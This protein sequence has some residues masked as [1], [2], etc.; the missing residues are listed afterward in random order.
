MANFNDTK[1]DQKY[2]KRNYVEVL[3]IL[4][5]DF[6]LDEDINTFGK[7]VSPI[8]ELINSHIR[9]ASSFNTI[10]NISGTTGGLP[11]RALSGI[12]SYF[13]KQNDILKLD[14]FDFERLVLSPLGKKLKD[15]TTSGEFR[16]YVVSSLLPNIRLN[17]PNYLFGQTTKADAHD[18]L[19]E[20]L[21]WLYFLNL[22]GPAG[23]SYQPSAYVAN[24]M[25]EKLYY[26]DTI[27]LNDGIKG[28]E[29]YI[30][31][32]TG[33]CSLF[34][35]FIPTNFTARTGQYTS[36]TQQLE[37]LETL[38]DVVYSPLKTDARDYRVQDAFDDYLSVGTYL[39]TLESSG[40]F[41]RLLKAISFGM[42]DINDQVSNL[43]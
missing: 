25:V 29:N 22:S 42:F 31:R 8:D 3:E 35:T 26:G 13:I 36:G 30:F 12:A 20:N 27:Y 7:Q 14:A 10:F 43:L 11:L 21:S 15:F 9:I 1:S 4:T 39:E 6:Y 28:L 18:Y 19:I 37:K 17:N 16:S 33:V 2:F 38:I 40:V 5:P 32:N 34:Q 24:L 23:L 41:H